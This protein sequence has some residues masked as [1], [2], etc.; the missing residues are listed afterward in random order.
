MTITAAAST[1]MDAIADW[2]KTITDHRYNPAADAYRLEKQQRLASAALVSTQ[3]TVDALL[4]QTGEN[5]TQSAID[6]L[7]PLSRPVT[8]H[9][10]AHPTWQTDNAIHAAL[11]Q[12]GVARAATMEFGWWHLLTM[13]LLQ[14]GDLPDPPVFLLHLDAPRK[15]PFDRSS[16][17][18]GHTQISAEER[19]GLDDAIRN[20]LRHGGGIWHRRGRW[21]VDAPLA[22]AWWRVEIA[23]GAAAA[24]GIG[25]L[26][27]EAVYAA[28]KIGWRHWASAAA[29]NS[30]RLAAPRC[31]AAYALAVDQHKQTTGS[32][33]SG[34]EAGTIVSRLLRRTQHLSVAHVAPQDLARLAA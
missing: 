6:T 7:P 28:L 30:T 24:N 10:L 23:R 16:L 3:A 18:D 14:T 31:A 34:P 22:A 15:L 32:P 20:L 2:Q 26:T 8:A 12:A 29:R 21:L 11:R 5:L 1:A 9:E 27:S 19:K 17:N 13:R 25:T 4:D 33:P